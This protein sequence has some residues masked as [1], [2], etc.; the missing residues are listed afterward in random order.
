MPDRKL[1]SRNRREFLQTGLATGAVI[2]TGIPASAQENPMPDGLRQALEH[3]KLGAVLGN[4][5]GDVTLTEF[6]DYNCPY[7]RASVADLHRLILEDQ[8]LRVVLREW[9]VFGAGS[10][11]CAKVSLASLRQG[12]FWQFHTSLMRI[13]GPADDKS[14]IATASSV[15]LNMGQLHRDMEDINIARQIEHS[16]ILAENMGLSGTP[17][18]IAGDFGAFGQQSLDELR[19][20]IAEVRGA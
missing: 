4:P 11:Y 14:A 17:T 1:P 15:G 7:C 16:W 8:Q 3:E 19:S 10:L 20:M 2:I 9:P 13:K 12:K 18:Y 5:S 6:F